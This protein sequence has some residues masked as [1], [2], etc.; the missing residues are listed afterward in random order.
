MQ[1]NRDEFDCLPASTNWHSQLRSRRGCWSGVH[2]GTHTCA[3][4][5]TDT[6]A[7][8]L[9]WSYQVRCFDQTLC[10]ELL[11]L[12][13]TTSSSSSPIYQFT[14]H[15]HVLTPPWQACRRTT[16]PTWL[17]LPICWPIG[18]I[19]RR[20]MG[21]RCECCVPLCGHSAPKSMRFSIG[22][23]GLYTP[24]S[25]RL[26]IVWTCS[27]VQTSPHSF[28]CGSIVCVCVCV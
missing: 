14:L 9:C 19:H 24:Y 16:D 18:S 17:F 12:S 6:S 22:Y 10:Y 23:S 28:S 5:R 26:M 3:N 1:W 7:E 20:C 8:R 2:F 4:D 13:R 15:T 11:S 21:N 25:M 27:F